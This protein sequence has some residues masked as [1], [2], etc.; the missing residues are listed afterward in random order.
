M[1]KN[2][3]FAIPFKNNKADRH[4]LGTVDLPLDGFQAHFLIPAIGLLLDLFSVLPDLL[5]A[6]P[7]VGGRILGFALLNIPEGRRGGTPAEER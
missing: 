7:E 3:L 1:Q 2:H 5:G 4:I 6:A